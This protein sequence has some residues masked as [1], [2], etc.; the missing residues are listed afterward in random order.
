M[1]EEDSL[2][3]KQRLNE[4]IRRALDA[5]VQSGALAAAQPWP[6]I[7]IDIPKIAAH[8]DFA[9]NIAMVLAKSLKMPPRAIGQAILSHIG[10]EDGFLASADMAGPGFMNFRIASKAWIDSLRA[11]HQSGSRYGASDMG[12]GKRIQVEFVSS[13]PTGPL[14]IGHG[15]G[16]AVGDSIANILAISGYDVQK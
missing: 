1:I 7:D 2:S 12:K 9:S 5:A 13:N 3:M 14:H 16:A 15:R 10:N 8:G 6:D 11:I 4:V